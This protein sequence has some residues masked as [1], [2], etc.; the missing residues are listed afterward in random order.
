MLPCEELGA[1]SVPWVSVPVKD[2]GE[3]RLGGGHLF[4]VEGTS[5]GAPWRTRKEAVPIEMLFSITGKRER[6]G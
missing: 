2:R 1:C 3:P 4:T 6:T 5:P